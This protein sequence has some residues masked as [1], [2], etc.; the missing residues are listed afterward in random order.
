MGV[1][2]NAVRAVTFAVAASEA[3]GTEEEQGSHEEEQSK[4][5][6][7]EPNKVPLATQSEI[8]VVGNSSRPDQAESVLID[9]GGGKTS[10]YVGNI[11][12]QEQYIEFQLAPDN[13]LRRVGSVR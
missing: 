12:G 3:E 7:E 10:W 2:H 13:E 5:R 8:R 11:R 4:A 1:D 9:D 6:D